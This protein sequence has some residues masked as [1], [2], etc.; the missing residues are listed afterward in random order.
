MSGRLSRTAS[1]QELWHEASIAGFEADHVV[2]DCG[3]CLDQPDEV[4]IN[5]CDHRLCGACLLLSRL[6]CA[7]LLLAVLRCGRTVLNGLLANGKR[8]WTPP[9]GGGRGP[10]GVL[11]F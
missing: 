7:V 8:S 6:C 4:A 9:P 3:I 10:G 2:E 1:K 11:Q 5:G